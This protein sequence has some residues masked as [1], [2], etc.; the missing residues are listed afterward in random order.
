MAELPT[1]ARAAIESGALVHLVTIN[2]DGSPQVACVWAGIDGDELVTGHLAANQQKLKNV[3]RDPRVALSVELPTRNAIGMQHYVV[4][5]GRARVTEGGAPELLHRLAQVYVGSGTRF[6]PMSNPPP[7][8]VMHIS[9]ERV[10]G[11]GPWSD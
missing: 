7:G 5:H 8:F 11:Y 3:A 6:P 9:I 2:S 1:E 10:G 4:L